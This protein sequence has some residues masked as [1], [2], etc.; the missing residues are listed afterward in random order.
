MRIAGVGRPQAGGRQDVNFDKPGL[1]RGR[2]ELKELVDL[3]PFQTGFLGAG[4]GS[5][6][7]QA[8]AM[9]NGQAAMELMGQWAPA[10]QAASST[11]K[12]GI[13]DK[14]GFF[15][16]PAVDGGKGAATDVVRRRQRLRGRQGRPAGDARLPEVLPRRG[17]ASSRATADRRRLPTAKG[18]EDAIKDPNA[19]IVAR[20]A[21]QATGF[22]LYLDQTYP[23]AVGQQVNDSVAELVA[24]TKTPEQVAE[25]ITKAAK[26]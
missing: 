24:G 9:G 17:A 13:G 1:R 4:Y 2:C 23:P 12:T 3:Q 5:P 6:D 21:D 25:D 20:D 11:S 18:A 14:L 10:V 15:P 8:A 16:F 22:Q 7:G 19:K 26:S